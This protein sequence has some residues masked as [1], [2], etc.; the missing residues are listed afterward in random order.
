[1]IETRERLHVLVDQLPAE[2]IPAVVRYLQ[3]LL[4]ADDPVLRAFRDAPE[5]EEPVSAEERAAIDAAWED[6]RARRLI[7]HEDFKRRHE[8]A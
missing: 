3:D 2:R 8:R 1:M 6:V 4:D 7:S 5:D